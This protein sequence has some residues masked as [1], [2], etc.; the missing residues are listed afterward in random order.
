[1]AF[2]NIVSSEFQFYIARIINFLKI[3]QSFL[4]YYK[5]Y[6]CQK[7]KNVENNFIFT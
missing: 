2:Q 3:Q 1:M 4:F 7:V 5:I 6:I